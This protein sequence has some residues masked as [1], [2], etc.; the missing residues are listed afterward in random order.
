MDTSLIVLGALVLFAVVVLLVV[1]Y[2]E[3]KIADQ[4]ESHMF[5]LQG[6][7]K[8]LNDLKGG[9]KR[10]SQQNAAGLRGSGDATIQL[11]LKKFESRLNDLTDQVA[12]YEREMVRQ[13]PQREGAPSNVEAP[14]VA[15]DPLEQIA[16]DYNEANRN[17]AAEVR[18]LDEHDIN[19]F[20]TEN[21]LE[22]HRNKATPPAA[23]HRSS[24]N[25]YYLAIEVPSRAGHFAVVPRFQLP[26][27]AV[28]HDAAAMGDAFECEG[29]ER[30]MAPKTVT[31][32]RPALFTKSGDGWTMAEKGH[33][34]LV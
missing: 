16:R 33:L 30:D 15:P 1:M 18:F 6:L 24:P 17:P 26:F 19:A 29:Y 13:K 8:T 32:K 23:I 5:Q 12:R 28:L 34:T 25:G 21:E 31:V 22:R 11:K 10:V 20:N 7:R 14:R 2:L 9:G 3:S 4:E 27:D